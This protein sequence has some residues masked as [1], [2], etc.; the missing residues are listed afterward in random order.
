VNPAGQRRLTMTEQRID[1]SDMQ[2][3]RIESA[4]AVGNR[5][6]KASD[7][8]ASGYVLEH[9]VC[10]N[11]HCNLLMVEGSLELIFCRLKWHKLSNLNRRSINGF[12]LS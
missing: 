11:S 2:R 10:C 1:W 5:F 12:K 3:Q 6:V 7:A 4:L 9:C 8:R